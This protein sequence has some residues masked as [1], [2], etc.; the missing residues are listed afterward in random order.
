VTIPSDASALAVDLTRQVA[1]FALLII[2]TFT[3]IS[4]GKVYN[5]LVYP[6]MALGIALGII[7]PM[8]GVPVP[9]ALDSL[10][11]LLL[12]F[13]IFGLFFSMGW[14]GAGDAKLA[15]AIGALHGYAFFLWAL[16]YMTLAGCMLAVVVLVWKG[17][18]LE[19]I[20][21]SV[22]FFFR[23]GK[24]KAKL[25]ASGKQ[26]VFIPYGVAMAAGTMVAWFLRPIA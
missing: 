9:S 3:D 4:A 20:K 15:A 14:L 21:N 5:W 1:L 17:M 12:G 22:L 8:L 25:E 6:V 24:L 16:V 11:G 26:P 19:T 10:I 23:P 7:G 18:L 2:A 13:C